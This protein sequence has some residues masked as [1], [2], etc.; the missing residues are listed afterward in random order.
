MINVKL[1]TTTSRT[2]L[3]MKIYETRTNI[4]EFYLDYDSVCV[5][6]T[7]QQYFYLF[8]ACDCPSGLCDSVGNCI[9]PPRVTGEDCDNC[10]PQT[11]GFDRLIGCEVRS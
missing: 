4:Y 7:N 6:N 1:D 5:L 11:F 9:C 3:V 2:V 10:L 8:P